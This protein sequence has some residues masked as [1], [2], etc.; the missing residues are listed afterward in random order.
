MAEAWHLLTVD[1]EHIEKTGSLLRTACIKA[2]SAIH[3][4]SVASG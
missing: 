3:C 4:L 1:E 2:G